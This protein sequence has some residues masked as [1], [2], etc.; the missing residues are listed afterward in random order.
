LGTALP[1]GGRTDNRASSLKRGEGRVRGE[2]EEWKEWVGL[3][4]IGAYY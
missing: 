2:Q 4:E 3:E 1:Q